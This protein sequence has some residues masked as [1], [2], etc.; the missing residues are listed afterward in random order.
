MSI[1]FVRGGGEFSTYPTLH[2]VFDVGG[3][4]I[5]PPP[6][7]YVFRP[8]TLG[9]VCIEGQRRQGY[10]KVGLD[11]SGSFLPGHKFLLQINFYIHFQFSA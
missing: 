1:L 11:V 7:L 5:G 8:A 2:P 9:G 3:L 10:A 4:I 6:K